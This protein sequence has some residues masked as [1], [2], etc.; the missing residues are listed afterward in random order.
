MN[1]GSSPA[2]DEGHADSVDVLVGTRARSAVLASR[3][4]EGWLSY[5][6]PAGCRAPGLCRAIAVGR[7]GL[8]LGF[9]RGSRGAWRTAARG[10]SV[11][12]SVQ[13]EWL[14]RAFLLP[15]GALQCAPIS[16]PQ[17]PGTKCST[18]SCFLP[19]CA[20]PLS[21]GVVRTCHVMV[22][23]VFTVLQHFA[24]LGFTMVLSP[25]GRPADSL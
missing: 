3:V 9:V 16:S 18:V 1:F 11:S 2:F 10:L 7:L 12:P 13:Q 25:F 20:R 21:P 19:C 8:S 14:R 15:R 23:V 17:I 6:H 22:A 4:S 5:R 24:S